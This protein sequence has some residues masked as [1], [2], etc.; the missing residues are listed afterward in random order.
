M[1]F[2]R[3]GKL[4]GASK[5]HDVEYL[6]QDLDFLSNGLQTRVWGLDKQWL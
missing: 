1:N 5:I 4:G 6:N 2:E 3:I